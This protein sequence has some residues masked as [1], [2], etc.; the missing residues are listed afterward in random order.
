V[1][2][3]GRR[4]NSLVL[5]VL[6]GAKDELPSKLEWCWTKSFVGRRRLKFVRCIMADF[7]VS[8]NHGRERGWR[9]LFGDSELFRLLL[10]CSGYWMLSFARHS[11][12]IRGPLGNV[13]GQ[14][15]CIAPHEV[16]GNEQRGPTNLLG[17]SWQSR[18]PSE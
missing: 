8:R 18:R 17:L 9:C 7:G 5:G 16:R 13:V 2:S 14:Q 6:L 4:T 1:S 15:I 11:C 3:W 10:R 12:W